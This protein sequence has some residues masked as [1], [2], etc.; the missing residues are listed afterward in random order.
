MMISEI[1]QWVEDNAEGIILDYDHVAMCLEH[2]QRWYHEGY[3]LGHFLTAVVR[4]DLC[5]ACF[6]ADDT[7]IRA[8]KLY[9]LFLHN[10]LPDDWKT[11]AKEE[12]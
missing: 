4:N 2:I 6:Q 1:R 10:H 5:E 12:I 7:N 9:A 3:P 8:L 11:K